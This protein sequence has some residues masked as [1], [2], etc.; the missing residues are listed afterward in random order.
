MKKIL[1]ILLTFSLFIG[2]A[3][4]GS[5]DDKTENPFIGDW[6]ESFS[7]SKR[8]IFNDQNILQIANKNQNTNEWTFEENT[9]YSYTDKKINYIDKKTGKTVSHSYEFSNSSFILENGE[10]YIKY[11]Q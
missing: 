5:D 9:T 1:F 7:G 6:V 2:F 4:C 10:S 11:N 8:M 3:S